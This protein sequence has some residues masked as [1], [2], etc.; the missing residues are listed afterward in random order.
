[1]LT[2]AILTRAD[3]TNANLRGA[4]FIDADLE[5]A[6]LTDASLEGADLSEA[7]GLVPKQL[8]SAV[9]NE[10][11]RL[12]VGFALTAEEAEVK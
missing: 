9:A 4:L 5:M 12:P 7:G 8:E 3:L 11:T 2:G 6:K 10:A 1:M